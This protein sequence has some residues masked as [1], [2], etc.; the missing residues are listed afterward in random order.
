MLALATFMVAMATSGAAQA[1]NAEAAGAVVVTGTHF[2]RANT[3]AA[4]MKAIRIARAHGR[5]VVFNP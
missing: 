2:A 5:K 3:A 1:Q 4:Q